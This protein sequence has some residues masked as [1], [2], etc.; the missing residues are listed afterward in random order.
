MKYIKNDRDKIIYDISEVNRI[1]GESPD[2]LVSEVEREFAD[3][4]R[5]AADSI[6]D[7]GHRIVLLSG[8]SASGKT[9]TA[10]ML[11]KYIAERRIDSLTV[12]MDNFFKGVD[13]IPILPNG[14]KNFDT[15]DAIDTETLDNCLN[16]LLRDGQADMPNFNFHIGKRDGY[17]P[18]RIKDNSLII[19]EGIH[20]LNPK[21]SENID[22]SNI[23]RVYIC[24]H[25][26]FYIDDELVYSR[27]QL[28]LTRRLIRDQAFRGASFGVTFDMWENVINSEKIYITPY[29]DNADIQINSVHAYE[30]LLYRDRFSRILSR[31]T[32]CHTQL[33]P[34]IRALYPFAK[35]K[36]DLPDG[37]LIREFLGEDE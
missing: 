29:M 33:I 17:T 23:F 30:P 13:H 7:S 16:Q 15:I 24:P 21:I 37:S 28:R 31:D 3:T 34:I 6:I 4:V 10:N 14:K 18:V 26:D 9:T 2:M 19:A 12:S 8:P 25:G 20:A 32:E 1:A 36:P 22:E 11:C 27:E 5:Q 35:I